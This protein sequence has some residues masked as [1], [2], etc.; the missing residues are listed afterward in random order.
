MKKIILSLVLL[1]VLGLTQEVVIKSECDKYLKEA[2]EYM[3]VLDDARQDT[4][5]RN[6]D[7]NIAIAYM[8]RYNICKANNLKEKNTSPSNFE[9]PVMDKKTQS[10]LGRTIKYLEK[11]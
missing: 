4:E 8:N 5:T 9:F 7:A 11:K 6:Q 10:S 3:G 2:D 1:S